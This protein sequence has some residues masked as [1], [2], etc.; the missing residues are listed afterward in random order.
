[1]KNTERKKKALNFDKKVLFKLSSTEYD[2]I[3][4]YCKENSTTLSKLI[5]DF[6]REKTA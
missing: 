2:K 5:R 6:I 1:M 4:L 3:K